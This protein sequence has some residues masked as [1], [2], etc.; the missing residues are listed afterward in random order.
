M[1][2]AAAT[3]SPA[4][5]FLPLIGLDHI[6]FYVGNARQAAHFYRSA[7]GMELIA[8]QGPETGIHD[9]ASYVLSQGS[10]RFVLTAALRPN[11]PIADHVYRY[12]DSVHSIAFTVDDAKAAFYEVKQRGGKIVQD[13]MEFRDEYGTVRTFALASC[14]ATVHT[15]VERHSYRGIFL[16][17]FTAT[18]VPDRMA[19]ASGLNRI[20]QIT[21]N[22]PAGGLEEW[23][24]KYE[25]VLNFVNPEG[26]KL[27]KRTQGGQ[28]I[29]LLLEEESGSRDLP[30]GSGVSQI[31]L[32]TSDLAATVSTMLDHG[33]EFHQT[34]HGAT[35]EEV[36]VVTKPVEDR[37]SLSYLILE[38]TSAC[39]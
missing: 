39:A 3:P 15:L 12:G 10:I 27:T 37:P 8:Y 20:H 34:G 6:E 38:H 29:R 30:T 16:P 28:S 36:Y 22:L 1:P 32:S 18:T 33:V 5:D 21:M 19:Y 23:L 2:Q 31:A 14:C 35:M 25:L 9:R 7:L 17:G 24:T 4:P 11:H 13:P 26:G